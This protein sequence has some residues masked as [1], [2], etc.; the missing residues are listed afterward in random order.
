[1]KIL[2]VVRDALTIVKSLLGTRNEPELALAE[3][4]LSSLASGI[5]SE[6]TPEALQ[7]RID[8]LRDTLAT[9]RAAADDALSKR[10]P[11]EDGA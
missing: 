3:S 1:M 9:D 4:I 5:D 10:F 6:L 11:E 7:K 8:M 2:E